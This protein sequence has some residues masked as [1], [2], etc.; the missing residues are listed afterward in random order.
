M[1]N[2][3]REDVISQIRVSKICKAKLQIALDKAAPT[4]QRYLDDNDILLTTDIA[5]ET[6]SLELNLSKDNLIDKN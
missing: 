2:K 4:I 3:L 5:L 6:I 1:S